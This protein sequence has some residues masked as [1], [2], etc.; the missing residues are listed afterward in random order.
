MS[1]NVNVQVPESKNHRDEMNG[2]DARQVLLL[3]DFAPPKHRDVIQNAIYGASQNQPSGKAL[4]TLIL[5]QWET[6][7]E[8]LE[9]AKRVNPTADLINVALTQKQKLIV[10][11]STQNPESVVLKRMVALDAFRNFAQNLDPLRHR[12]A[13]TL[14]DQSPARGFHFPLIFFLANKLEY[15][16]RNIVFDLANGMPIAGPVAPTPGL[17]TRKRQAQMSYQQWKREI[18]KR[19]KEAID[20]LLKTQGTELSIKCW[21]ETLTGVNAGWVTEPIDLTEFNKTSTPLTPRYAIREQHGNQPSK[22]RLIDDFR[23]SWVNAIIETEDTN[24]PDS[25]DAFIAVASYIKILAPGCQLMCGAMA[26]KN[27]RF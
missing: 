22:V 8:H 12:W 23:A 17:P 11:N 13:R 25:L 24:I 27:E 10:I 1:C 9:A 20:R 15:E 3:E 5:G 26:F 14:P 16:D 19:N 6:P 18:P 7:K 2:S 4:P 21:E